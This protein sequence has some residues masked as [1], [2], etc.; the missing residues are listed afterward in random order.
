MNRN[1]DEA[2]NTKD[3]KYYE[4]HISPTAFV[5]A[6]GRTFSDIPFS[7]EI[8]EAIRDRALMGETAHHEV[9]ARKTAPRWEARYKI[10]NKLIDKTGV[11]DVI[12][13][14]AGLSPRGLEYS[15]QHKANF[16]E[17][18]LPH[19]VQ[20]KS[21]IIDVVTGGGVSSIKQ[22]AGNVLN[23]EDLEKAKA[24][25]DS[26]GPIV[27][28]NEGLMRYFNFDEKKIMA[29]NIQRTLKDHGGFWITTDVSLLSFHYGTMKDLEKTISTIS[30][31]DLSKNYF[32]SINH[33]ISFF[34]EVGF[35]VSVHSFLEV[36]GEI[37]SAK[38][39]GI[40]DREVDKQLSISVAFSMTPK[41]K[42]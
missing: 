10:I 25:L 11:S 2:D 39:L 28:T 32:N 33:A 17:F 23:R 37:T 15:K 35:G 38:R 16:V 20:M 22:V 42:S 31:V 41:S 14:A 6:Y 24:A 34:E 4:E 1:K 40:D 19:L 29:E 7:V 30:R 21:D 5:P 9:S 27:I 13:V 36:V 8:Y 18:D 3:S 26:K 12:E